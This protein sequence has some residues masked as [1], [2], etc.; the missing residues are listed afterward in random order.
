VAKTALSPRE[1]LYCRLIGIAVCLF[2]GSLAIMY[3][4]RLCSDLRRT[5][6]AGTSTAAL[7]AIVLLLSYNEADWFFHR[8]MSP[9]S[10][11]VIA[12]GLICFCLSAWA[13]FGRRYLLARMFAAGEIMLLLVGWALAHQPYL[14][15]PDVTLVAAAGPLATIQFLVLAV[16]VGLAVLIPS[17]VFLL[18]VFKSS[19]EAQRQP[20]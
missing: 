13:V 19:A 9:S 18:R 17:L 5:I 10:I 3:V 6:L 15:Y 20:R 12:A 7:S 4:M 1:T 14:I 11:P 2:Y 16:P 8:L